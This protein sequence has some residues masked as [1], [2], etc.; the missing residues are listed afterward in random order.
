MN[1]KMLKLINWLQNNT[2]LAD[3]LLA[4]GMDSTSTPNNPNGYNAVIERWLSEQ[5]KND[6]VINELIDD[7]I[8]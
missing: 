2:N 8:I 4:D 3:I 5:I 6:N 1:V 7:S